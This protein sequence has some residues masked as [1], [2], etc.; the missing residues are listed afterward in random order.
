M[1]LLFIIDLV[2]RESV[3]LVGLSVNKEFLEGPGLSSGGKNCC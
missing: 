3:F 1:R 2:V